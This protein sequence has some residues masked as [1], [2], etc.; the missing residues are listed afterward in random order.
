MHDYFSKYQNQ[1]NVS[2]KQL[3]ILYLKH[4]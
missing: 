3:F 1:C 4:R 2:I